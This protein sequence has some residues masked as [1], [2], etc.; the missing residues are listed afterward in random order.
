MLEHRPSV[1]CQDDPQTTLTQSSPKPSEQDVTTPTIRELVAQIASGDEK[2]MTAL[3]VT[4][5][6]RHLHALAKSVGPEEAPDRVHNTWLICVEAIQ[7]GRLRAP[8]CL[9]AFVATVAHRQECA[10]I[11]ERVRSRVRD[12]MSDG[13]EVIDD[14]PDPE[15]E[16]IHAERTEIMRKQ[17]EAMRPSDREILTRFYLEGQSPDQICREMGL[18]ETQFR[19]L[20]SRGKSK[21]TEMVSGRSARKILLLLRMA[22]LSQR[23]YGPRQP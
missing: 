6:R 11:E 8:E 2:A 23:E 12:V 3:Y 19:L 21:L 17:L 18:S 1:V 14:G 7:R 13:L 22:S 4:I 16:A 20:K 15:S 5:R 10:A 9:W